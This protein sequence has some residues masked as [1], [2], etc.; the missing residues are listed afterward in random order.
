MGSNKL[1]LLGKRCKT[2]EGYTCVK[3]VMNQHLMQEGLPIPKAFSCERDHTIKLSP[4][5]VIVSRQ[6]YLIFPTLEQVA[7]IFFFSVK[8]L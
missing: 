5:Q 7:F 3:P 6:L 1:H 8:Q 4:N 2:A